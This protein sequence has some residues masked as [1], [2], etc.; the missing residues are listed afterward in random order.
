MKHTG[1]CFGSLI[2]GMILGSALSLLFTPQSGPELRRQIKDFFETE[3]DK[4]QEKLRKMQ[5]KV[6]KAACKCND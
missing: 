5:E 6:E 3:S 4:L 1:F 2:G